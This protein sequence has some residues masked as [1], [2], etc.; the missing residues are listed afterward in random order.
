MCF[1]IKFS[2]MKPTALASVSNW[3]TYPSPAVSVAGW[4]TLSTKHLIPMNIKTS[5]LP[6]IASFYDCI[7]CQSLN[8]TIS[9]NTVEKTTTLILWGAEYS[10]FPMI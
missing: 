8:I 1:Q 7:I 3:L 5:Q 10:Q 6:K 9:H 4:E 2:F